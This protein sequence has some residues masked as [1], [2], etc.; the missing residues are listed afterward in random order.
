MCEAVGAQRIS[1]AGQAADQT[2][3]IKIIIGG[4]RVEHEQSMHCNARAAK[5]CLCATTAV[6]YSGIFSLR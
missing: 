2:D 6:Q 4:R 3:G 5:I 1:P